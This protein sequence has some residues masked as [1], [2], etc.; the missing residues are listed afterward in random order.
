MIV[1]DSSGSRIASDGP[2]KKKNERLRLMN[3]VVNPTARL[4]DTKVAPL[5]LIE[6]STTRC[7]A[8]DSLRKEHMS[9]LVVVVLILF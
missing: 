2:S 4:L 1:W 8:V 9:V 3:F 6:Q 7:V 5:F